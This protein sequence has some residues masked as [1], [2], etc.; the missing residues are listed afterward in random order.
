MNESIVCRH[1][2]VKW[3]MT[4]WTQTVTINKHK[5]GERIETSTDCGYISFIVWGNKT[6][7][8]DHKVLLYN[9]NI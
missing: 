7:K 8:L 3:W 1:L 2:L 5:T 6:F 4:R 9:W